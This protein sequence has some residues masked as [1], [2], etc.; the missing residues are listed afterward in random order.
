M[1]GGRVG[2]DLLGRRRGEESTCRG[3]GGRK[4]LVCRSRR[5]SLVLRRGKREACRSRRRSTG[6]KLRLSKEGVIVLVA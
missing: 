4:E 5:E 3:S 1:K 6:R 2:R